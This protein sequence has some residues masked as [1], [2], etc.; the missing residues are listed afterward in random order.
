MPTVYI[1]AQQA[2][3]QYFGLTVYPGVFV[4]NVKVPS[5]PPPGDN[6]VGFFYLNIQS[7]WGPPG[8]NGQPTLLSTTIAVK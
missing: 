3:V 5:G 8:A 2:E 6:K 7:T 4:M 1:G